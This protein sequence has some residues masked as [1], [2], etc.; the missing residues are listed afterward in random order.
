MRAFAVTGNCERRPFGQDYSL[1][2]VTDGGSLSNPLT[3]VPS[4]PVL[5]RDDALC[6]LWH[7]M[8][9]VYKKP[10]LNIRTCLYTPVVCESPES[11][12]SAT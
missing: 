8:D 3:E 10:R 12:V 2:A 1:R 11:I 9:E 4:P 7:K 5:I 6:K